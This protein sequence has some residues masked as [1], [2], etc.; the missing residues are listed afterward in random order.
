M[1]RPRQSQDE[2]KVSPDWRCGCG[3]S[4]YGERERCPVCGD[5]RDGS[6]KAADDPCGWTEDEVNGFWDTAC[7]EAFV[8]TTEGPP[9]SHKMKWC[10]Y[11]GHRI[12]ER[13]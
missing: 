2:T 9:S 11:C 4:V 8:T 3:Q 12:E 7:G 13:R 10:P 5:Y 6:A 1:T